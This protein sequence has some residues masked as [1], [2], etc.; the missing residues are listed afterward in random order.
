M[1]KEKEKPMKKRNIL[2]LVLAL[3]MAFALFG[4]AKQESGGSSG[5]KIDKKKD[6][7]VFGGSRS[8]TG[9]YA[10]FEQSAYGPIYKMWVDDINT[11]GAFMSRNT[12]RR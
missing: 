4:C 3:L 10:F 7:I 8:M 9:V 5:Y 12:A 2:A 1:M 6:T 11:E